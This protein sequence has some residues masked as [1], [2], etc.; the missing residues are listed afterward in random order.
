MRTVGS[1]VSKLAYAEDIDPLAAQTVAE[2][3]E[4]ARGGLALLGFEGEAATS[5][6]EKARAQYLA[7]LNLCDSPIEQ[8]MLAGMAFM[9][10]PMSD[11]FPPAIHDVM[12]GDP[13]PVQPVVIAPQ[14]NIARYRLD[15]LVQIKTNRRLTQI[16]VECDGKQFHSERDAMLAD[17]A[18][19]AYLRALGIRTIRY[20]GSWIYRNSTTVA[21]EI[22][23]IVADE[24]RRNE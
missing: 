4:R 2:C 10:V 9:V 22:A 15:F 5:L 18:R 14:F 6:I 19:D 1:L 11:C 21:D 7:H 12:S 16:V 20:R 3:S 13:W 17:E 23:S 8:V 24:S